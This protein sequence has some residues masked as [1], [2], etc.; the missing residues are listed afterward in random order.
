MKVLN[1][2]FSNFER[3]FRS[4]CLNEQSCMK[5]HNFEN[6][7]QHRTS[8]AREKTPW[9]TKGSPSDHKSIKI[10]QVAPLSKK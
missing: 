1:E 3:A 8:T 5:L 2:M 10:F 7:S 6:F 4:L 9:I